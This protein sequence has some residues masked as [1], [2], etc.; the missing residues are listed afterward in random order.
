MTDTVTAQPRRKRAAA[1]APAPVAPAPRLPQVQRQ[2]RLGLAALATLLI[3]GF[4]ALAGAM[5]LRSGDRVSVVT[6]VRPVAAGAQVQAA[7]LGVAEV[8]ADGIGTVPAAARSS[9]IGQYAVVSLISGTLLSPA[10]LT[11][12]GLPRA[13]DAVVGLQLAPGRLPADGLRPGDA[14][15]VVRVAEENGSA[16][17]PAAVN[18]VLVSRATVLKVSADSVSGGTSVTVLVAESEANAL[19]V[20]AARGQVA[21]AR[22]AKKS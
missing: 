1:S 17:T 7:D 9:L 14:L 4:G 2:R 19:T 8:A 20:A 12:E 3:V 16:S 22:I 18:P 6:V 15:R 10:A 21:V 13:G 11:S 5:V